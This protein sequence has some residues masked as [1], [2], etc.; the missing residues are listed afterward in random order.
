MAPAPVPSGRVLRDRSADR[1][2]RVDGFV[3]VPGLLD[4]ATVGKVRAAYGELHG[5]HG[6]GFEPDLINPD[7][8]YR[9]SA[10]EVLGDSLDGRSTD[11]FVDH[12]PF[13]RNF[14]CKWPGEDSELYLHRDWTYVDERD[15]L[16]SFVVWIALE[17]VAGHNGQ[18]RVLRGSHR[19]DSMLRGTSLEAPWMEHESTIRANLES[20]PLLAGDA[21][22]FDN[23]LVH[24]SYPNN[25]ENPRLCAAV[26]MRPS[27]AGLVYWRRATADTAEL[28]LVDESFFVRETPQTL[29]ERAPE[30]PVAETSPHG[31][32][33]WSAA[34]LSEHISQVRPGTGPIDRLRRVAAAN[35]LRRLLAS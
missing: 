8:D 25:S 27:E 21:I 3:V 34:Q 16:R 23:A 14:L 2:L 30:I 18:L 31:A 28:R 22:V 6:R 5:W 13:L 17:D 35:G 12:V 10:S 24:C 20:V 1:R 11:L 7:L 26:G 32:V 29:I 33:E 9:A 4:P 19:L 15:G